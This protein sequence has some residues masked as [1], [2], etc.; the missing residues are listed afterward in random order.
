M[1]IRIITYM[2]S[3]IELSNTSVHTTSVIT[4]NIITENN[5]DSHIIQVAAIATPEDINNYPLEIL[6]TEQDI[7]TTV[8]HD[9]VHKI[10]HIILQIIHNKQLHVQFHNIEPIYTFLKIRSH[11]FEYYIILFIINLIYN[12]CNML[13]VVMFIPLFY[14]LYVILYP[15]IEHLEIIPYTI[16]LGII[17][18]IGMDLGI[19]LNIYILGIQ[20]IQYINPII[21]STIIFYISLLYLFSLS[22]IIVKCI[23]LRD[24][25]YLKRCYMKLQIYL[26]HNQRIHNI[27]SQNTIA[28]NAIT[29]NTLQ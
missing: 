19:T 6:D 21:H 25:I 23:F 20:Y 9:T 7:N 10:N 11:V 1:I 18:N 14:Y 29:E 28:Q 3:S 15:S 5:T 2:Q 16:I 24:I 22:N 27:F 26:L 17:I 8:T 12:V 4:S 13:N